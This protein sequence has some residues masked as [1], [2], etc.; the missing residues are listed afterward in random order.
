MLETFLLFSFSFWSFHARSLF[1][2][3]AHNNIPD[4]LQADTELEFRGWIDSLM[5]E[6]KRLIAEKEKCFALN[7]KTIQ[8]NGT[9][10]ASF[11][12]SDQSNFVTE[13]DTDLVSGNLC[14]LFILIIRYIF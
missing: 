5:H 4:A 9:N 8:S 13:L 14:F 12:V 3:N 7:Q 1:L 2:I 10:L 11:R 6:I